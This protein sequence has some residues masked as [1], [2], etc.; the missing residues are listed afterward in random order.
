MPRKIS[1]ER[2]CGEHAHK[3]MIDPSIA[4]HSGRR[5]QL[6]QAGWC[7]RDLAEEQTKVSDYAK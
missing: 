7:L 1:E 6:E 4:K 5:P 3:E 2:M